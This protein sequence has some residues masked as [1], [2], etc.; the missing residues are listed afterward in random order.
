MGKLAVGELS[1]DIPAHTDE[2]RAYA[3]HSDKGSG[4][5]EAQTKGVIPKKFTKIWRESLAFQS[6]DE[7]DTS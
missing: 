7:G 2:S 5:R 1:E 3:N 4:H 6:G